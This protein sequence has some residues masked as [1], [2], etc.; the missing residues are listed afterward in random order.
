M[1][2]EYLW[3]VWKFRLLKRKELH[4]TTGEILTIQKPGDHN[5]D[6]GPDFFNARLTIGPTSWAGNVEVHVRSSDWYKHNHE[7]D[8]AYD[9]IVLHVV[10]EDDMP[11][12]RS[13]GEPIPTLELKDLIHPKSYRR[14]LEFRSSCDWVACEKDLADAD[15][16]L[17]DGW[18]DRLVAERLER[19]ANSL[20]ESLIQCKQDWDEVFYRHLC[21]GF[22]HKVNADP[23]EMLARHVPFTVLRKHRDSRFQTE[24]LLFGTAGFLELNFKSDYPSALKKEFEFLRK[25][26]PVIPMTAASWKFMRL[27]PPGFPTFR[28]S[29][30]AA[31][32]HVHPR[33][34]SG[35]LE[36]ESLEEAMALFQVEAGP[37]WREHYRF[38]RK[39]KEVTARRIGE[40]MVGTLLINTIVPLL[41]LYGK[42]MGEERFCDRALH[43]L[44]QLPEENNTVIRKW[45]SAGVSSRNAYRSQGLL[46]LKNEYCL[47]KRC[48]DCRIGNQLLQKSELKESG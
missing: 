37:Y 48:L 5:T 31:F 13:Q 27:H 14:Y 19:K 18:L 38:E 6:S 20:R 9:S 3:Y 1:T 7:E 22:G 28:I 29:Q 24:A 8:P 36:I 46:Q 10:H 4:T 26:F 16:F 25:K 40:Q 44:E 15:P 34:F 12:K 21:R 45:H 11:V 41:F 39:S 23:F 42:E 47:R 43:W 35:I 33:P 17:V 30:L 2:E 32:L